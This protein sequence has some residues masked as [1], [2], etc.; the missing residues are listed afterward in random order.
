[1]VKM[2]APVC[3][4]HYPSP[5][6]VHPKG[7]WWKECIASGHDPYVTKKEV[8]HTIPKYEERDGE[9]YRVGVDIV[10][11]LVEIPNWEQV[12]LDVK[13]YSGRG[14]A[15]AIE[16]GWLMPEDKGYA[17]FCEFLGCWNQNPQFRTPVGRYCNRDQA[18]MMVLYTGGRPDSVE[19]TPTF[20][21]FGDDVDR[22]RRQL[23]M[24]PV[25]RDS[26]RGASAHEASHS[27][28]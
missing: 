5:Q 24:T 6:A 20:V 19:G 2:L 26:G 14:L 22:L 23:D 25:D 13:A 16:R 12:P 15:D 7:G 3:D 17:S 11:K 18:A 10:V 4:E 27:H 8:E 21:N 1:M 9:T 28:G